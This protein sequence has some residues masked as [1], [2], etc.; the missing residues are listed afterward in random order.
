M[1]FSLEENFAMGIIKVVSAHKVYR[2]KLE[3]K[4]VLNDF[5]MNVKRGSMYYKVWKRVFDNFVT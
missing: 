3:S 5:H 2:S 1:S 4:V